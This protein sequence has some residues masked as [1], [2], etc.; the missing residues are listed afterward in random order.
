M[1]SLS[2]RVGVTN[3]ANSYR[4]QPSR[5]TVEGAIAII[6]AWGKRPSMNELAEKVSRNIKMLDKMI[7]DGT[8][9]ISAVGKDFVIAETI[10]GIRNAKTKEELIAVKVLPA[11]LK[12]ANDQ[13]RYKF[14]DMLEEVMNRVQ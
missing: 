11:L 4:N 2:G 9:D 8:A 10:C 13:H 12:R 3:K 5:R 7:E 1:L 14:A 6:D